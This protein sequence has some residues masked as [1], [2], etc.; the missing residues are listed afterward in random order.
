M[1]LQFA[2]EGSRMMEAP[3]PHTTTFAS[4]KGLAQVS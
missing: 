3:Q 4:C 1:V 2:F